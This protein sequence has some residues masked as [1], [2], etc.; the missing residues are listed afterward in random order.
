[1]A[2]ENYTKCSSPANVCRG[3][4]QI[5][6]YGG[7]F[8][9][10]VICPAIANGFTFR[11][12]ERFVKLGIPIERTVSLGVSP[13][14]AEVAVRDS[15]ATKKQASGNTRRSL[16]S[17]CNS[18]CGFFIISASCQEKPGHAFKQTILPARA[19]FCMASRSSA[20]FS[21][22]WPEK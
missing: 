11:L 15:A 12:A 4:L 18:S 8:E 9:F 22:P 2:L 19:A 14:V 17:R 13:G 6:R 1:M 3:F 21:L 20:I 5:D 10:A 16:A 7:A